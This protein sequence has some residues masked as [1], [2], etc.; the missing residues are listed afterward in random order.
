MT[1]TEELLEVIPMHGTTTR[2]DIFDTLMIA[3]KKYDLPM[4]K[5]VSLATGGA[6]SMT[7]AIS[8]VVGR[9][10]DYVKIQHN[11]SFQHFHCII[12]QQVLCSKLFKIDNVF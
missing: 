2:D 7:G 10:K 12:H 8:G 5:L 1:I 11:I 9:L 3:I 4:N 6:P